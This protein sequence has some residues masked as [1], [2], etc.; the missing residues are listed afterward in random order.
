MV[1]EAW[2]SHHRAIPVK[3]AYP[4]DFAGYHKV[5]ALRRCG[6]LPPELRSTLLQRAGR[7]QRAIVTA[8]SLPQ[9][10]RQTFATGDAVHAPPCNTTDAQQNPA[11]FR[12]LSP[13]CEQVAPHGR[14]LS[15]LACAR[16]A[17]IKLTQQSAS[18]RREA[19]VI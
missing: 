15:V 3:R 5:R 11:V 16:P 19:R 8:G 18:R 6:G 7:T 13:R 4:S 9:L 12:F 14:R 17:P 10:D 1:R 2:T